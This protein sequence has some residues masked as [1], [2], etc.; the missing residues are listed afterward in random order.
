VDSVILWKNPETFEWDCEWFDTHDAAIAELDRYR[1]KY[2]WNTYYLL[3]VDQEVKATKQWEPPYK[4]TI[5]DPPS[6]P[7]AKTIR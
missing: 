1:V 2:P 5:I 3:H 7:E 4:M 6:F